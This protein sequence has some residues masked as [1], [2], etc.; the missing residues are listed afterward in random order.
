ML[1]IG[2][3]SSEGKK[4]Q[5]SLQRKIEVEKT[6]QRNMTVMSCYPMTIS[7]INKITIATINIG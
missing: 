4:Q 6:N 5:Q 1:T 2:Q 7:L 3:I